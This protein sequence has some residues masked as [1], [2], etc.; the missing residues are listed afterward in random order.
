MKK[1]SL[2]SR[3]SQLTAVAVAV[4]YCLPIVFISG[5]KINIC[6]FV[7]NISVMLSKKEVN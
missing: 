5:K 7:K 6:I 3:P 1:M 4:F 2:T